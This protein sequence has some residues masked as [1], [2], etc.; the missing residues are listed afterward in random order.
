MTGQ[1]PL[2]DVRGSGGESGDRQGHI[3]LDSYDCI[4]GRTKELG[5]AVCMNCWNHLPESKRELVWERRF[6]LVE[7]FLRGYI[8][9]Q[10]A[11]EEFSAMFS[12]SQ[13]LGGEES[14]R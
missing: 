14:T 9:R 5:H 1:A 10:K 11:R 3:E 7:R 2:S 8:E 12:G 6:D 4:C 13:R